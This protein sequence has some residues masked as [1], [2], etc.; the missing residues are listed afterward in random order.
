MG[1]ETGNYPRLGRRKMSLTSQVDN[2]VVR[3]CGNR[4][5]IRTH[6]PQVVD[7]M[8]SLSITVGKSLKL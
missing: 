8:V 3:E 6:W 2:D 4:M 1:L 7:P 5:C